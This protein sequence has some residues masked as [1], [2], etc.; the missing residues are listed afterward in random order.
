ML[1]VA[2]LLDFS[3]GE[4]GVGGGSQKQEER[5]GSAFSLLV[6]LHGVVLRLVI[7]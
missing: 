1:C 2:V 3:A 4:T 7:G 5:R 6:P